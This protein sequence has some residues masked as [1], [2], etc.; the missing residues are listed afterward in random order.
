MTHPQWERALRL[1]VQL[2][3]TRNL[4]YIFTDCQKLQNSEA[5]E[6]L[7]F[8]ETTGLQAAKVGFEAYP[9]YCTCIGLSSCSLLS[10]C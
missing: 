2:D 4:R 3:L 6:S 10:M 7:Q 9:L 1:T 5:N 8:I